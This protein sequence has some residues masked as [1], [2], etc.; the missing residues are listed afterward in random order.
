MLVPYSILAQRLLIVKDIIWHDLNAFIRF[1]PWKQTRPLLLRDRR[2]W[3]YSVILIFGVIFMFGFIFFLSFI[4]SL[5]QSFDQFVKPVQFIIYWTSQLNS[6]RL[7]KSAPWHLGWLYRPLFVP[8]TVTGC[9]VRSSLMV[10]ARSLA[11]R[12]RSL[13]FFA[14]LFPD[15]LGSISSRSR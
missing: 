2:Y 9:L 14:A 10:R 8:G 7:I 15:L 3:L 12:R 13:A 11:L 6:S 5:F 1:C 4:K